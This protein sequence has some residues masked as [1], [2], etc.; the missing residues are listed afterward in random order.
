[1]RLLRRTGFPW[2]EFYSQMAEYTSYESDVD[3]MSQFGNYFD[4]AEMHEMAE[5][6]D[7]TMPAMAVPVSQFNS[8]LLLIGEERH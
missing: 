4:V 6:Q 3:V 7:V 5:A 2:T 8:L 1:M